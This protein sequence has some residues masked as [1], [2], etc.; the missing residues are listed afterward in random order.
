MTGGWRKIAQCLCTKKKK[1][2]TTNSLFLSMCHKYNVKLERITR[3]SRWISCFGYNKNHIND[4][5]Y[6]HMWDAC[7][8][9][10]DI[11]IF[12]RLNWIKFYCIFQSIR[13]YFSIRLCTHYQCICM[14]LWSNRSLCC[15]L[16]QPES[17]LTYCRVKNRMRAYTHM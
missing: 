1:K 7:S 13:M 8:S 12:V 14:I 6:A 17:W 4:K 15:S 5:S 3:K 10:L 11:D 9:I 16:V 2:T